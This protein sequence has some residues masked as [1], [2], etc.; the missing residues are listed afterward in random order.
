MLEAYVDDYFK[1]DG[2]IRKL[3]IFDESMV[4]ALVYS[5]NCDEISSLLSKVLR[6]HRVDVAFQKALPNEICEFFKE[7]NEL[8]TYKEKILTAGT[9]KEIEVEPNTSYLSGFT[10]PELVRY[11]RVIETNLG[12]T[13][14]YRS[15]LLAS[16]APEE[17]RRMS[18]VSMQGKP[19]MLVTKEL[20][21]DEIE[22]LV[23]TD[24]SR[25]FRRLFRY[26]Q[27]TDGKKVRIYKTLN[28]RWDD[29]LGVWCFPLNSGKESVKKAFE[30]EGN[31]NQYLSEIVQIVKKH[32]GIRKEERAMEN[33]PDI[34]ERKEKYLF[35]HSKQIKNIPLQVQ[36]RLIK[37]GLVQ[38]DEIDE[39]FYFETFGRETATDEYKDCEVVIFIG[40]LHK[41][42]SAINALLAGEGFTGDP[43]AVRQDVETGELLQQI[44]QGIGRG[45]LRRGDRQFVYFFHHK[46]ELFGP[47]I[48]KA[49]IACCYN[50][51]EADYMFPDPFDDYPHSEEEVSPFESV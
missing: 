39:R 11:S 2:R 34:L 40:L 5:E 16:R 9:D 28:F 7:L 1:Y 3:L 6:K 23:T 47:D 45:Q 21:D 35:F 44:Q 43:D 17:L 48:Q 46:P 8:V 13:D 51:N 18:I 25:E 12:K 4:N 33:M 27:R 37:E 42:S 19:A 14:L 41:P 15:I 30:G 49:F 10:Y 22:N 26:T 50:G 29:E 36:L 20:L 38:H 32:D 31:S 24:A